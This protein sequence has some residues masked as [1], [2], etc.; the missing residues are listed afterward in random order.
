MRDKI[1]HLGE[2]VN[3]ES[4]HID[5]ELSQLLEQ[6]QEYNRNSINLIASENYASQAVRSYQGSTLTNKYA[7]GYPQ[8]RYYGGCQTIDQ[9][10][11]LAI[12][13]AKKLFKCT[14]ANVQPHSGSQANHAVFSSLLKPGDT[15][16]GM[17]LSHGGH[18]THGSSVNFSGHYYQIIPYGLCR[19]TN[20]IDY[21]QVRELAIKH[22]PKL[23]IAGFSAYSGTLDWK[24]F[25]AIS[26]E[27]GALLLADIAHISGLIAAGQYPSPMDD[28]DI[29]TSTTHKTL[30]GPRSGIIL[31]KRR[32]DLFKRLDFGVFPMTQGG[33]LIHV[34]AAK[35]AAFQEALMPDFV[36]Y[37]QQIIANARA[38]QQ[39]LEQNG[40]TTVWKQIDNHIILVDLSNIGVT[41]HEAQQLLEQAGI[42]VNKNT[43]PNDPLPPQV[44][45]GIRIGTAAITTRGLVQ[46]DMA[47][48]AGWIAQILVAKQPPLE[49]R[50]TVKQF[51]SQY[52]LF[53]E[54]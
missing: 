1:Q 45:S 48:I 41:G 38:L 34:I 36:T 46:Q 7:E 42:I 26:D 54:S 37:Q 29:V 35:A 23:I 24:A 17:K 30:R 5:S 9:I 6:E 50:Q 33:P 32:P 52:K 31:A 49:I 2:S 51:I 40:L 39:H 11:Q 15:I 3:N 44:T 4:G 16:L 53:M 27:V 19:K 43:I 10:E 13:R 12:D 47:A 18:L 25:R 22:K 21:D 14:Y 20:L 8:K 28:A